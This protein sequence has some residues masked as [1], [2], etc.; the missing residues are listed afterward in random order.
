MLSEDVK[1]FEKFSEEKIK[2]KVMYNVGKLVF[3]LLY[4]LKYD[5]VTC[6]D[7]MESYYKVYK[8]RFYRKVN[9]AYIGQVMRYYK[10]FF[11]VKHMFVDHRKITIY[12]K[13]D[14]VYIPE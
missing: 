8:G 2:A 11:K 1:R 3:I 14:N 9:S 6:R 7:I 4:V 10:D 12:V 13:R 5:K